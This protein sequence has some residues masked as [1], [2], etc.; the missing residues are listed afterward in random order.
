MV[1]DKADAAPVEPFGYE[2]DNRIIQTADEIVADTVPENEQVICGFVFV[3]EKTLFKFNYNE[4]LQI[5]K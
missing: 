1:S 4:F 3:F 2:E 5:I